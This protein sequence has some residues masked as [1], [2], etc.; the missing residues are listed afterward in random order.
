M[1]SYRQWLRK[2]QHLPTTQQVRDFYSLVQ[3]CLEEKLAPEGASVQFSC[4]L[5][6]FPFTHWG[7]AG[8]NPAD[9]ALP[10]QQARVDLYGYLRMVIIDAQTS[11][12]WARTQRQTVN[13]VPSEFIERHTTVLTGRSWKED[14]SQCIQGMMAEARQLAKLDNPTRR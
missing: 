12:W 10:I 11:D 13:E 14:L 3:R 6:E 2:S 8:G 4:Y 9:L 7:M 5:A 1:E